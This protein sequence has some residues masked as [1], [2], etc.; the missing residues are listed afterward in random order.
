MGDKLLSFTKGEI[1]MPEQFKEDEVLKRVHQDLLGSHKSIEDL[2]AAVE[3]IVHRYPRMDI[4]EI[5][6][7]F[8]A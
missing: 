5:G 6:E 4:L 8:F 3:Q 1:F 7:A 2:G